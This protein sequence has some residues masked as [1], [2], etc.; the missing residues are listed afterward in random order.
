MNEKTAIEDPVNFNVKHPLKNKWTLWFDNP[1]KKANDANWGASMKRLITID[2]VEDFWGYNLFYLI[3][4]VF[5]TILQK[6]LKYK[7]IPIFI[8]SKKE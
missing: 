8:Y 6:L 2:T 4:T 5:I 3:Y 1:G 7:S